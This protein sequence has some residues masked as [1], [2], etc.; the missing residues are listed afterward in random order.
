MKFAVALCLLM[1][2]SG[3]A[4]VPKHPADLVSMLARQQFA[5]RTLMAAPEARD[6]STLINDCFNHYLEDQTNVIMGYNLQY[7]GCLRSAQ[8]GRDELT[9]E[10]ASERQALLERT[11]SMCYSLTQCDTLVDGLEFFDCYR[12]ASSDSYKVMFTLNSDSS[13]DF[14]R[15]SAKYQV[16]ETDLT[17]CVDEARLDYAHDMDSCDENLTICLKGGETEPTTT[18]PAAP[19][20]TTTTEAPVTTTSPAAPEPTTTSAAPETTTTTEAPVTTTTTEAPVTTTS[21][22]APEPTTTSAAPETTTSTE[23]PETTTTTEAPVTTTSPAAPEPTTTPAAPETTP[24]APETTTTTEA[25]VTTTTT[26]APVTTIP[27]A[28]EPT[29][30]PAAPETTPAAPETTTTTE[31]PVTTTT[32]EAPVTTT[33]PAAPE[34]TTTPAAPETTT[35]EPTTTSERPPEEDINRL[36]RFGQRRSWNLFKRFF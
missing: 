2:T 15:I 14:N 17:A 31:A 1:A 10:S 18:T 9:K 28:P 36:Q 32:T 26:E 21:P 4:M 29:T 8:S 16:I 30:T 5:V 33:S 3:F 23:A 19:E 7:T 13:L 22:A 25:P 20:T 27:A 12:N 11:N 35:P 6:E 34:P 24:A